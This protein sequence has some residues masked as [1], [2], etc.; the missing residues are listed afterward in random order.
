M[1]FS[2][3]MK[4]VITFCLPVLVLAF[5]IPNSARAI[6]L[7]SCPDCDGD[8]FAITYQLE[9]DNGTTSVYDVTLFADTSGNNLGGGHID[10]VALG[11]N[12]VAVEAVMDAAPNG[13]GNWTGMGG[14]LNAGGCD[15]NGAFICAK[16]N[17]STF[18]A[19]APNPST[20]TT[21]YQWTWDVDVL[22][23]IQGGAASVFANGS[24]VKIHYNDIMGHLVSDD[25]SYTSTAVPE[26]GLASLL[27]FGALALAWISRR[28]SRRSENI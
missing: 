11:L 24:G 27:G 15:G 13:A 23:N 28:N 8:L 1:H 9:S 22:D 20:A 5:A 7:T 19:L 3:K 14:G 25:F 10:A 16:A 12:N 4:T 2:T 18:A 26:P 17:S 6:T 21:P